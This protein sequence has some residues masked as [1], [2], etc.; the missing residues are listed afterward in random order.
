[1]TKLFNLLSEMTRL[2]FYWPIRFRK[3]WSPNNLLYRLE[4]HIG[5]HCIPLT[6]FWFNQ[7]N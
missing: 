6:G 7:W 1:M 5:Y 2:D 4:L 3:C